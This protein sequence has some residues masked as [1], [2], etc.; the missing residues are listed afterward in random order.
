MSVFLKAIE[1]LKEKGWTKGAYSRLEPNETTRYGLQP[2]G[3]C[4]V[5]ACAEAAFPFVNDI[6]ALL[7]L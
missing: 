1:I 3:Y 4:L 5:G 7:Y 6:N 2:A